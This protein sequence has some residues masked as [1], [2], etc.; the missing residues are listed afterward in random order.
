MEAAAENNNQLVKLLEAPG[1]KQLG[2]MLALAGA[3]AI[4]IGIFSWSQKPPYM[5]LYAGLADKDAAEV[6][7]AMRAANIPFRIEATG[8]ISVPEEMVREARL[9]LAAQGLPHG[10]R[11]GIE[12]IERDQG[13]GVSQF[14]ESARYQ[15]AL[16]TELV[17]TITALKPV[18]NARVH[19]AIPKP[20]AFTKDRQPASASVFVELYQGRVLEDDQVAAIVHLVA[21][22]IPE[23]SPKSVTVIDQF[24]RLLTRSSSDSPLSATVAQFEQIRR[25]E[26]SYV[27][28]IREL[29]EPLTGPGKVSTQ[30][31]VDLDFDVAEEASESFTPDQT[32]VRSEQLAEETRQGPPAAQGIPGSTTNT[33]PAT[34][35]NAS[36]GA[37]ATPVSQSKSA[38][39]NF[40]MDRLVSH[41]KQQVGSVRRVSV[42][43]L[44]D[45]INKL[46][47]DG[48][49]SVVP[50][51]ADQLKRIEALI[52][53]AVG[54]DE[55][56][57]DTVSVMNAAFAPVDAIVD[58]GPPIWEQV[59]ARDLGRYIVALLALVALIYFVIR[60]A[61]RHMLGQKPQ[62]VEAQVVPPQ[63]LNAENQGAAD[64]VPDLA[65]DKVD[66]G[67]LTEEKSRQMATCCL[68]TT[69]PVRRTWPKKQERR[70]CKPMKC[71]K[72]R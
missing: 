38:T 5:P 29:L 14:V 9:K 10:G 21:S 40:E 52:K 24:G 19:L 16:E 50:L 63:Q 64:A 49:K 26:N 41:K 65:E 54:F 23:M 17:R 43:V 34:A 62:P 59:W 3:I 45:N 47:A 61:V 20:S 6:T 30:V 1:V 11:D 18:R 7:D 4:G 15:H 42:A 22:S 67:A 12:L 35:T 27:S 71:G 70:P 60:P 8:A 51:S 32:K 57:G 48:K 31:S 25:V 36:S 53:E 46:G 66:L 72:K 44:I 2:M 56:R 55:K 13:F 39:R 69:G 28:R 58:T 33:P 37:G 68:S